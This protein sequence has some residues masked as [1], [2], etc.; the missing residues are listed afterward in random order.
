M[1]RASPTSS[2]GKNSHAE[3]FWTELEA[4]SLR[5]EKGGSYVWFANGSSG[6]CGAPGSCAADGDD[7]SRQNVS[8]GRPPRST[9]RIRD[10]R[11]ACVHR[12]RRHHFSDGA[13]VQGF[14]AGVDVV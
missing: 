3:R 1:K 14:V 13:D 6:R 8:Q 5:I 10:G 9:D 2:G 12:K 11:H 4:N 7:G